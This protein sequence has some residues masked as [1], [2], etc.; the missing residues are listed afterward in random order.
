MKKVK[1]R[2]PL[3][4]LI[5]ASKNALKKIKLDA[6]KDYEEVK[7][8]DN[9]SKTK[10]KLKESKNTPTNSVTE[11]KTKDNKKSIKTKETKNSSSLKKKNTSL[12]DKK[13]KKEQK[14]KRSLWKKIITI[15]L[16]MGITGILLMTV[17]FGYI[18]I[19][20][21]KFSEEAFHEKDQTII[22][23]ANGDVIT[24]LGLE[25]RESVNYQ[26]LPQVLIDAIIATEDSRFFQHNGV[27]LPRFM[28][29]TLLQLIGRDEAGGAS[30]ITM[31]MVKNSLTKKDKSEANM[32]KKIVRKF[33]D[34]YLSVFKVEKEYSKEEIIELYVNNY[35]LG[36]NVYGVG[37]AAKYYFGKSVS[38]LTLPEAS[39]IAG[40]FQAPNKHNPYKNIES[41]TKRRNTVL[42]L[43]VRHGYITKEEAQI[44]KDIPIESLLVGVK[45]DNNYQG[46][47]DV[48]VNEAMELTKT[49][50]YE[51]DNPYVVPMKIYT[52]M[53]KDIQDGVNEALN[54]NSAWYWKNDDLL[55]G[56]VAVVNVK[57]G[58][59]SAI[60]N[61]RNRTGKML[62]NFATE[63]LRQPGSTAK[64]LFDYGPGIEYNNF[65][66]YTMFND[67]P[68]TYTDGPSIN[69]WDGTFQGLVTTR[70]ALQFS[71]NVPA[72]KAF[73]T[74]GPKNIQKF[75][76]NLGLDVAL[77]KDSENYRIVNKTTGVD[78][79][80]N[81][82][83]AI[84]GAAEGF[85][86]LTMAAAYSGFASGGYYTKPYSI[87]KIEY[88]ETGDIKE[89]K[90]TK[91]RVM[92]D[93][94]AYIMNNILE[95]AVQSGFNGGAAISGSH[96]AAK[97]GTSNYDE[98]TMKKYHLPESA[99]NDLWTI[100][101]TPDYSVAVWYGYESIY[102]KKTD[103]ITY[104]TNGGGYKEA[105]VSA[106]MKHIPKNT[107]G[108]SMP[109]SVVASKVEKESWPAKLPSEFTPSDQ[110]LTEY[111]VRGTQ[112]SEISKRYDKLNN[113]TNVKTKNDKNSVTITWDYSLPD[114]LKEEYLKKQFNQSLYG[115]QKEKYLKERLEY[116]KNTLG[117]IGFGIYK[118]EKNG[119]LT[120]IKY[121]KDK[122]YTYTGYGNTTLV[123]KAEHEFFKSNTSSGVEV[124][125]SLGDIPKGTLIT[126]LNG[127]II[128][129]CNVGSYKEKGI[130]SITYT[131]SEDGNINVLDK[132]NIKY[133]V[134]SKEK[135]QEFNNIT[136]LEN[137]I[138]TLPKGNYKITYIINYLDK[139]N[140][141]V[142]EIKL[143]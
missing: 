43:M 115:N 135:L 67:E 11:K 10:N 74:V 2:K 27:D 46:F 107:V 106:V 7:K 63:A 68:W 22:Y 62:F 108:W 69:N 73:Q 121:V 65:S 32:I 52:T 78:N 133:Q 136:S 95:S 34:V 141:K 49:E 92:K 137:Y 16:V 82:A 59:I 55:Q 48:V 123:I 104:N 85:S 76:Y 57:T 28:K 79:T 87:T 105:F 41:A 37:E 111:F 66:S 20:A 5:N 113:I 36:S 19:S 90:P 30:T 21:P 51:G 40:L 138:N 23:D 124:N 98:A 42:N 112:P 126:I 117:D 83:Y 38:D 96:V 110:I 15:I 91:T 58:A 118:K 125:I 120:L 130:K 13:N 54:N 77:N 142:R 128:E 131:T 44:A 61:G 33:Q 56:A 70:Y 116:N 94:T 25:R 47:I 132:A 17:F 45:N 81:E 140:I 18:I 3:K 9:S 101:Y 143:N 35:G 86:P 122:T 26:Q 134:N 80:I 1:K 119:T 127:N 53:E 72:L 129:N 24:T 114:I 109:S 29:A 8:K 60:G 100:A 14:A 97:T 6:K 12:K 50:D 139:E 84:G 102:D 103:R 64:P 71:R 89:Y 88:R 93:S 99:V 39:L 31:Q 4:K 75:V